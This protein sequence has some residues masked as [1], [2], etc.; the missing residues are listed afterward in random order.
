[1]ITIRRA[2]LKDIQSLSRKF[3][4]MLEDKN[5]KVYQDNVAKF[6]IPNEY[7]R[8]ALAEET[9]VKAV[10]SGKASF[11][12]ALENNEIIGFAQTL[13]QDIHIAELDRIVIFPSHERKGV[14]TQLLKQIIIDE[15]KKGVKTIMVNAG[16]EEIH[17][18]RFYEKN[19]FTLVKEATV[20]T[21]W[22]R[23]LDLAIYQLQLE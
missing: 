7:V 17:A 14:G 18:R 3:L 10:A 19:G 5:S 13:Q 11:Y 8:K 21:P 9:L 2:T 6:N 12:L 22:K 4:Q 16:K 20:D 15:K 1:M 23:K